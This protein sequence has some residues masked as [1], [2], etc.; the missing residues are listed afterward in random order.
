MGANT[1]KYSIVSFLLGE[2]KGALLG[3]EPVVIDFA[4]CVQCAPKWPKTCS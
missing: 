2:E 3:K 4:M 1:Q